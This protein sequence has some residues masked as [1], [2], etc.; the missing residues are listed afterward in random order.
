MPAP[1]RSTRFTVNGTARP[2][3]KHQ[4][5]AARFLGGQRFVLSRTKLIHY[6]GLVTH[7]IVVA[8]ELYDK[9]YASLLGMNSDLIIV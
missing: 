9:R 8:K 2:L 1:F 4:A 6:S 7:Y 3:Q 5:A